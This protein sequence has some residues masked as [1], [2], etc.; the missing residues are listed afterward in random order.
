[1]ASTA[2]RNAAS[3]TPIGEMIPALSKSSTDL[4]GSGWS[5]KVAALCGSSA[6]SV[7]LI[8]PENLNGPLAM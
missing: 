4:E 2:L 8:E 7:Q 1:M 3:F 6:R 5:V